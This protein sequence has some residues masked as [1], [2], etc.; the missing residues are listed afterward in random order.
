[1]VWMV[2]LREGVELSAFISPSLR[3][4]TVQR[5]SVLFDSGGRS[6]TLNAKNVVVVYLIAPTCRG[7]VKEHRVG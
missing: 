7:R 2:R 6:V 4:V 1:M 3:L 5:A